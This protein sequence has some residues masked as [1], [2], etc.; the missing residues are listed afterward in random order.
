M[1]MQNLQ[2]PHL[3]FICAIMDHRQLS[4]HRESLMENSQGEAVSIRKVDLNLFRVFE[5]V[6]VHR[7]I[8][9]ASRE[10]HLTPSAVSHALARLRTVLADRLFVA[11]D[12]V[13]TPTARALELAPH[14]RAGLHRI[15][16]ALVR[17]DFDPGA[18]SRVFRLAASDYGSATVI[19]RLAA[20][21]ARSAPRV[22]LR[23]FPL[24]RMDTVR[25]LDDG[26]IDM[27]ISW[28][29]QLPPHMRKHT[30]WEDKETVI[31]RKGH[32]LTEGVMTRER[33]LSYP[34]IVV[35]LTGT[36]DSTPSGY[37]DDLGV[38]RRVWIERFLMEIR[39]DGETVVGRAA[40]SVPHYAS[41]IPTVMQTD[42]VATLPH[43]L[44]HE[45]IGRGEVAALTLPYDP[46]R[47]NVQMI[48][49]ERS[50]QDP[51]FK[52]LISEAIAT[53]PAS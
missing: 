12:G 32:P 24:N 37:L 53:M 18:T 36:N 22:D 41:V 46:L 8:I 34:H 26:R 23:V 28:F 51:A 27:A 16:G 14:I 9:G 50:E 7:S 38:S 43:G 3:D 29:T 39:D 19:P 20:R 49:H 42:M 15:D 13:M 21:L 2:S 17:Q 33:L 48:W 4:R 31:V 1:G 35:E 30:L 52:W 6:M 25:Q 10:L 5:A 44:V 47:V 11:G 45:A 40:V